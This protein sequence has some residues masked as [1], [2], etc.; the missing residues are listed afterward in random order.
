MAQMGRR[1]DQRDTQHSGLTPG[2]V[3][4]IFVLT[5][6]AGT[7]SSGTGSGVQQ[8]ATEQGGPTEQGG[9]TQ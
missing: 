3:E 7:T 2:E 4:E 6:A 5:P 1:W 8:D 9:A